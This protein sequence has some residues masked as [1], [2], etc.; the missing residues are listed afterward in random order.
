MHAFIAAGGIP[1][2]G[3]PL[4]QLTKGLNKA[5]LSIAG[6]PMI[7]WIVDAASESGVIDS[8]TIIGLDNTQ[9]LLSRLPLHYLSDQGSLVSNVRAGAALIKQIYPDADVLMALP[10]DIPA[11]T[12]EIIAEMAQSFQ[13][14]NHDLYY[15][16]VEKV[17]MEAKFPGSNRTYVK[18]RDKTVCGGDIHA[19]SIA[20]ALNENALYNTLFNTRKNP[21]RQAFMV[22]I[23]ILALLLLKRLSLEET[24]DR[25]G[26]RLGLNAR[27]VVCPFAEAGMDVDKPFQF[28][29]VENYLLKRVQ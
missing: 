24:A 1:A 11:V 21:L 13:Q 6:K 26:K 7:Q 28:E 23:D 18:L 20:T 10:A 4:F 8:I 15:S 9:N 17:V 25:V 29:I 19:V 3:E 12:P 14:T 27:A 2:S 16:V 22:G 5:L